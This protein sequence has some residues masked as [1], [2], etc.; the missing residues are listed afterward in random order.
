[1]NC[2]LCKHCGKPSNTAAN[3][4]ILRIAVLVCGGIGAIV[5]GAALPLLGFGLGGIISGSFAAFIQGPA[6]IAGSAFAVLQSLG[7]TGM[8]ILLFGNVGAA[9]GILAPH[10]AVIGWCNGCRQKDI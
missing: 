6:V 5:G 1:M 4:Q 7:A 9:I 2:I 10:V 3:I 8:G